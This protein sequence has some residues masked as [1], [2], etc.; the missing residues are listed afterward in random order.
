MRIIDQTVRRVIKGEK[1]PATDK[2][3]SVFKPYT[4]IAV[5]D[6]CDTY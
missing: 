1:V 5:E 3:V 2:V 4:D 6:R